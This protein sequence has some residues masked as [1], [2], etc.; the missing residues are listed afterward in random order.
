MSAVRAGLREHF[1]EARNSRAYDPNDVVAGRR[2]VHR[3]V[4][5]VHY[6]ERLHE[7]VSTAASGHYE[8]T[9]RSYRP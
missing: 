7:A 9:A 2:Y 3:Y 4:E 1:E 5:F 8:E 6:A